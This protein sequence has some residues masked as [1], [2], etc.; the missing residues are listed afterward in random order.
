M[1]WWRMSTWS[2]CVTM[3]GYRFCT[4][5][6]STEGHSSPT[7][8]SM[9][10]IVYLDQGVSTPHDKAVAYRALG[11]DVQVMAAFNE[12]IAASR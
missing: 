5:G 7:G 4:G 3:T 11:C 10:R 9:A 2:W 12:I 8:T 6:A 1:P